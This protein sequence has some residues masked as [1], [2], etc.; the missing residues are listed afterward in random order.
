[1][2]RNPFDESNRLE[3]SVLSPNIFRFANISTPDR[4]PSS[5]WNIDQR[6]VLYPADINTDESSLISQYI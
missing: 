6:A 4:D 3:E 2:S 5:L 1:M